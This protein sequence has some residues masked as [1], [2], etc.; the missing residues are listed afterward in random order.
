M[1]D[2]RGTDRGGALVPGRLPAAPLP[3][4]RQ[5]AGD[6]LERPSPHPRPPRGTGRDPAGGSRRPAAAGSHEGQ[7]P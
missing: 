7:W 6:D 3:G 4:A 1:A 5:P 2:R